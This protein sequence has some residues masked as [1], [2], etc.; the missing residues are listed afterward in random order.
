[1]WYLWKLW[2]KK[3]TDCAYFFHVGDKTKLWTAP[4]HRFFSYLHPLSPVTNGLS[5]WTGKARVIG[6]VQTDMSGTVESVDRVGS[7]RLVQLRHQC[8][9]AI[10]TNCWASCSHAALRVLPRKDSSKTSGNNKLVDLV[11]LSMKCW[12]WK[13]PWHPDSSDGLAPSILG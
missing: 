1:M 3:I 11:A 5:Y 9:K 6:D 12:I 10:K 8:I 7:V 4:D 13:A 2:M